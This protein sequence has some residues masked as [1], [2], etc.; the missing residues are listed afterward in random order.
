MWLYHLVFQIFSSK[1]GPIL[2]DNWW[3]NFKKAWERATFSHA[4]KSSVTLEKVRSR[5]LP[6]RRPRQWSR[7][8]PLDCGLRPLKISPILEENIIFDYNKTAFFHLLI[9]LVAWLAC[10]PHSCPTH[11]F[12][13]GQ[14][15][16]H[17]WGKHTP[18]HS[19]NHFIIS[20]NICLFNWHSSAIFLQWEQNR[21]ETMA[22]AKLGLTNVSLFPGL[23]DRTT[24]AIP[25]KAQGTY[26]T[27]TKKKTCTTSA[28]VALY[29][30]V[31]SRPG[32]SCMNLSLLT[33][34]LRHGSK[35]IFTVHDDVLQSLGPSVCGGQ[36]R[37]D[38]GLQLGRQKKSLGRK[39]G[40][41]KIKA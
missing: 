22:L 41:G 5:L 26:K 15:W 29:S 2:T 38:Q 33:I 37:Q 7:S 6:E 21:S 19:W 16:G 36:L 20:K 18:S 39:Q 14:S 40:K 27:K 25:P 17:S 12:N 3:Q 9:S 30:D 32:W 13:P 34:N 28:M 10:F 31:T 4:Q 35:H 8:S 23:V 11:P 1:L 24:A